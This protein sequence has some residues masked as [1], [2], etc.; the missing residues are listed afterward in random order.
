MPFKQ[1]LK[2]TILFYLAI[3]FLRHPVQCQSVDSI[4]AK[5]KDNKVNIGYNLNGPKN[6][7]YYVTVAFSKDEGKTFSPLLQQISGDANK[8][9]MTGKQKLIEWDAA[10][11]TGSLEDN[12]IFKIKAEALDTLPKSIKL[13]PGTLIVDEVLRK[14]ENIKVIMRFISGLDEPVGVFGIEDSPIIYT[15]ENEIVYGQ[16]GYI[17]AI[18]FNKNM[19]IKSFEVKQNY[20][21][22]GSI[23]F[24][25]SKDYYLLRDLIIRI[26]IK[27]QNPWEYHF[28]N[29]M[30]K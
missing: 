3:L 25:F 27:G 15:A 19:Q 12:I 11:E 18:R 5:V 2:L 14:E 26:A 23:T 21:I 9:V 1:I 24:P 7:G 6:Q 10:K 4:Q 20:A 29:I 8:A 13:P 17:G 22:F 16:N 30:I 28:K